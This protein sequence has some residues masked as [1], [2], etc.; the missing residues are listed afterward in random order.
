MAKTKRQRRKYL[1]FLDKSKE[2][3]ECAID[4]F[5]RAKGPF[6]TEATLMLLG[7]AWEL[8]AKAILIQM[9]K[10]IKKAN[11]EDT[12]SAEVAVSRLLSEK[13]I[14][15]HHSDIVQQ[16]ISLRNASVHDVLPDIPI[17]V[18]HHLMYYACKFYR[19]VVTKHFKGHASDLSQH[20]LSLSFDEMTTYADKVHKTVSKVRKNDSAKKLVWLLERGIAFDGRKYLTQKQFDAKLKGKSRTLPY[21]ELG[22]HMKESDMVRIIPVEAP[23]NYTADLTLRKGSPNDSS[24]PVV[25][26]RTDPE[27]DYPYLTSELANIIGKSTQFVAKAA[28]DL[29]LKGNDKFHQTI[30]TSRSG[31]IQRYS[32]AAKSRLQQK[33]KKDPAYNPYQS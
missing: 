17:E 25:V 12:I 16:I 32:E 31:K 7:V 21:L 11:S 3:A 24:L 13:K 6:R 28:A 2:S 27:K 29:G 20:Y 9:K 18:Q 26:K 10:P 14:E 8:L 23:K 33:L 5:N 4:N 1:R 30:R 15:K 22:M 19:E